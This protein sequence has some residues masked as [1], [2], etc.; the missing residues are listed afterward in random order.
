MLGVSDVSR[1]KDSTA[2]IFYRTIKTSTCSQMALWGLSLLSYYTIFGLESTILETISFHFYYLFFVLTFIKFFTHTH[3]NRTIKYISHCMRPEARR[4]FC[5]CFRLKQ[6]EK[7]ERKQAQQRLQG[8]VY[9]ISQ[10]ITT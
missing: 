9:T 10:I 4:L 7:T 1:R 3:F 5:W 6:S 8:L 2:Q